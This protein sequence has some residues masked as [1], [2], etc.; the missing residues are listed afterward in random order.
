MK[1]FK[2]TLFL[3]FLSFFF[4]S[5]SVQARGGGGCFIA[6]TEVLLPS[7]ETIKIENIQIGDTILAFT[8]TL[9]AVPT[10]VKNVFKFE[11]PS[12]YEV[13]TSAGTIQVTG[14]HPFLYSPSDLPNLKHFKRV[15]DFVVG[16]TLFVWSPNLNQPKPA[17]VVRQRLVHIP[18]EVYNI[19]TEGPH[20]YFANLFLVHN[21]GGYDGGSYS[22]SSDSYG[23]KSES[24]NIDFK[25]EDLLNPDFYIYSV[26]PII[27]FVCFVSLFLL[28]LLSFQNPRDADLDFVFSRP[29]IEAKSLKT[30]RL[31]EFIA[32][33]DPSFNTESLKN[34]AQEVFL[35]LQEC[36]Q[37]QSYEPMKL[38]LLE[39]LFEDHCTQI[40]AQ[41]RDNERNILENLKVV[42]VDLV[43]IRY[44][45][46]PE[47]REFAVLITAKARDIYVSLDKKKFIRGDEEPAEFQEFW[48]FY[49]V[50]DNWVL[51][52]IEQTGESDLLT[53]ENFF[54]AFT[55][56]QVAQVYKDSVDALGV[57]GPWASTHV[58]KKSQR[59][60]RML[61]HLIQVDPIWDKKKMLSVV[62]KT[63]TKVHVSLSALELDTEI[64]SLMTPEALA[65]L[66][67]SLDDQKTEGTR[68]EYRN[69]CIRKI[70]IVLVENG[71][72]A[73]EDQFFAR[74]S[75]HAHRIMNT[76]GNLKNLDST[77]LP[78]EEIWHFVRQ[79]DSW[80]FKGVVP[81]VDHNK[82]VKRENRDHEA[83]KEM[84]KWYY[85]R[86]RAI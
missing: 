58:V 50:K 36:W 54:E 57:A 69:F 20:T 14:D 26:L 31:V 19:E 77:V 28:F 55:D 75:A 1:F 18:T 8:P 46:N 12:F 16:D 25:F 3:V 62:R 27:A 65:Q 44:T 80:S 74:I 37:E 24:S 64:P 32:K 52:A 48:K 73:K 23:K 2:T 6:G 82:V 67:Q 83:S 72:K 61:N 60:D 63:F 33:Q 85:T 9:E 38:L 21:K 42:S 78:F 70:E 4:L 43:H 15:R 30:E 47:S 5:S 84:V 39:D 86:K 7:L 68:I 10:R 17:W 34:R 40:E 79:G 53:E 13:K 76:Q 66:R 41:I 11:A 29:Q 35:K 81:S 59:I 22:Y 45:E 56:S 49:W 71:S 51:G